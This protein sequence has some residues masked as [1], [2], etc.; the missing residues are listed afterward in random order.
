[1]AVLR[2]GL[3]HIARLL[4]CFHLFTSDKRQCDVCKWLDIPL[5]Q[6]LPVPLDK[7]RDSCGSCQ[8]VKS[9]M[10]H[11]SEGDVIFKMEIKRLAEAV[12]LLFD[13]GPAPTTSGR[14]KY[15]EIIIYTRAQ[16]CP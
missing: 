8:L 13:T 16:V 9:V 12:V 2:R 3:G 7:L 11:F 14:T 6:Y 15:H 1:M 10:E 4:D 5:R